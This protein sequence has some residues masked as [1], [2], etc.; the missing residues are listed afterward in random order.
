MFLLKYPTYRIPPS[1]YHAF[2]PLSRI[3]DL[4]FQI[5]RFICCYHCCL[6]IPWDYH[7]DVPNV[8]STPESINIYRV[9]SLWYIISHYCLRVNIITLSP[10]LSFPFLVFKFWFSLLCSSELLSSKLYTCFYSCTVKI[11]INI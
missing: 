7:S 9:V 11:S 4:I 8:T 10:S 3:Q 1:F 2:E 5:G 6:A